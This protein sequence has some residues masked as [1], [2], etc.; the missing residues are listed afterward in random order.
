MN[1][2]ITVYV[3]KYLS[4]VEILY[5]LKVS[6]SDLCAIVLITDRLRTF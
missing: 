1:K 5:I 6:S 4:L 2:I 3:Y